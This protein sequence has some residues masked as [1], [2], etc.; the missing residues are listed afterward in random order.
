MTMSG[1]FVDHGIRIL[2]ALALLAVMCSP[3]RPNR[4]LHTAP[5]PNSL[6]RNLVTLKFEYRG[7]FAI[8]TCPS[9]READSLRSDFEDKLDAD[10]ED[11]LILASPPA[12]VAFD[13]LLSPYPEPCFEL[14]SF[15]VALV[16]R[17]LRC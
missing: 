4:A 1:R 16:A 14:V 15:A 2:A 17:P 9:L 6:P 3:I 5:P 8:L 10:I 11:E 12:S 7:Q 13:V